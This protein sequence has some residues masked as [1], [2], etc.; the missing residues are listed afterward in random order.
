MRF[1]PG[2]KRNLPRRHRYFRQCRVV[3]NTRARI[4]GE[5]AIDSAAEQHRAD[6]LASGD[7]RR[8]QQTFC[9]HRHGVY[10]WMLAA[11]AMAV[12]LG[13]LI[14][15]VPLVRAQGKTLQRQENSR[16]ERLHRILDDRGS[17]NA[18]R[19][20]TIIDNHQKGLLTS[21]T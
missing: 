1:F 3:G 9:R 12:V 18:R 15:H 17:A 13:Y 5:R 16:Q 2:S 8:V 6:G 20:Q 10:L 21:E 14:G 11:C 7:E 19:L 4:A